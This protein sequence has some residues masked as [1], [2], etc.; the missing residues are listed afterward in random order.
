MN[1]PL[2]CFVH[3]EQTGLIDRYTITDY[4]I[5]HGRKNDIVYHFRAKVN[6]KNFEVF[7]V[8]DSNLNVLRYGKY[9]T[10]DDD[11]NKACKAI[12]ETY[13]NNARQAHRDYVEYSQRAEDIK[14]MF[15]DSY[16]NITKTPW[17]K[18]NTFT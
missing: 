12:F 1:K 3:H 13:V 11:V 5:L 15:P 10:F 2:Y 7:D 8:K 17:R 16:K 18:K 14:V 9:Y 4:T 6:S